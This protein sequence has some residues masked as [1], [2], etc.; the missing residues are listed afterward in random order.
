MLTACLNWCLVT[1]C[2]VG[3]SYVSGVW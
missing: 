1:W 2:L 3:D